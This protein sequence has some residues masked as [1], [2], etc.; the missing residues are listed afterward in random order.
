VVSRE[1]IQWITDW[2]VASK[3]PKPGRE[4]IPKP[5]AQSGIDELAEGGIEDEH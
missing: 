1:T 2:V 3:S 4:I 5:V